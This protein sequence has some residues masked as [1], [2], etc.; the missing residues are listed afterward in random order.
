MKKEEGQVTS[1]IKIGLLNGCQVQLFFTL[2][3]K[4]KST[5]SSLHSGIYLSLMS[6][7][8]EVSFF[9]V[10]NNIIM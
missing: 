1:W 2:S 10:L 3:H 6:G 8:G 5:V 4:R 9:F 7:E